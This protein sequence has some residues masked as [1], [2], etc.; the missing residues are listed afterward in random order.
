M[1]ERPSVPNRRWRSF[2]FPEVDRRLSAM[3]TAQISAN[4]T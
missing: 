3:T 4:R 1:A 2:G